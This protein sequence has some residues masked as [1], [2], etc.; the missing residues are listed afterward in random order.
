MKILAAV[1]LAAAPAFASGGSHAGGRAAA[2]GGH[3][4]AARASS[5]SAPGLALRS[6]TAARFTPRTAFFASGSSARSS[7]ALSHLSGLGSGFS[8]HVPLTGGSTASRG[9]A[10]P[11]AAG[12]MMLGTAIG[13]SG[14]LGTQTV[15]AG[16][17]AQNPAV[18]TDVDRSAGVFWGAPLPAVGALGGTGATTNSAPGSLSGA[19]PFN[20]SSLSAPMGQG[21]APGGL[22]GGT[23]GGSGG[24]FASGF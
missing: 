20:G 1:L 8:G 3:V 14:G 13:G 5:G 19:T 16:A 7:H 18:A 15:A 11:A 4:A 12:T 9:N 17:I 22:S 23:F 21:N 6:F 2:R 10:G 24:S